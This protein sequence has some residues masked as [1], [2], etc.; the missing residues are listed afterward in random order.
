MSGKRLNLEDINKK[1]QTGDQQANNDSNKKPTEY[2]ERR[3][4]A[5][6]AN[7][8]GKREKKVVYRIDPAICMIRED[9]DRDYSKLNEARCRDLI[10]AFKAHGQESPALVRKID[11]EKG[12]EYEI[13]YGS[14]RHW[15]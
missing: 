9:H 5:T 4:K 12:Y 10:D 1:V 8:R 13:V 14:R 15:T 2:L 6:K 3:F 7:I 11:N